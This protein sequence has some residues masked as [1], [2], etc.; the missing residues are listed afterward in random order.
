MRHRFW[1]ASVIG[2]LSFVAGSN[3][4]GLPPFD[5]LFL[6]NEGRSSVYELALARLAQERA[7]RPAVKAYAEI[8]AQDHGP[9]DAALHDLAAKKGV[10]LET[11][12]SPQNQAAL[13][14]LRQ[15]Q[16]TAFD[17]AFLAEARRV[18]RAEMRA[19]R[20]EASKTTDPDIRR[21]VADALSM[22][23]RHDKLAQQAGP[24]RGMPVI[25]PPAAGRMPILSP[26]SGGTTPVIPPPR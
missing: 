12:L 15:T 20:A 14:R 13:D 6:Q 17:T 18:N 11:E 23:E 8:L 25:K 7:A 3:A 9:H 5:Q 1:L 10:T 21:F 22:D 2:V 24:R 26:P 16:G 19:F 4:Q